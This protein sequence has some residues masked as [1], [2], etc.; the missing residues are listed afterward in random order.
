MN[1]SDIYKLR[2]NNPEIKDFYVGSSVS[3]WGRYL[4]HRKACNDSNNRYYENPLYI[5]IRENGGMENWTC[6]LVA[7]CERHLQRQVEQ[8]WIDKL[9]PTLNTRRAY[10]DK[11]QAKEQAKELR[12]IYDAENAEIIAQ[13]KKEWR[14]NP[15]VKEREKKQAKV[16]RE[17]NPEKRAELKREWTEKNREHVNAYVNA[18]YQTNKDAINAKRRELYKLKSE[19]TL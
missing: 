5:F 1:T 4:L 18:R 15:D 7:Q 12:K 11:E 13:K 19:N 10:T 14:E 3:L 16:W 2:A 8:E 9:K 6:E 17:N